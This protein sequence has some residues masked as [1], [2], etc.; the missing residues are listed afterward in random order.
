[1]SIVQF[2]AHQ[3]DHSLALRQYAERKLDKLLTDQR[4][5]R[6]NMTFTIENQQQVVKVVLRLPR[7][8]TVVLKQETRDMYASIDLLVHRIYKTVHEYEDQMRRKRAA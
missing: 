5:L 1:M 8:M 3:C 6:L 4:V 2:T 7:K